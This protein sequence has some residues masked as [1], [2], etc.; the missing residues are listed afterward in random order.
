VKSFKGDNVNDFHVDKREPDPDRLVQAYFHSAATINY[1]RAMILGGVAD[2]HH[3][4]SWNLDF[5]QQQSTRKEYELIIE[6]ITDGLDF[7]QAIH[8]DKQLDALKSVDMYTSHEGLLLN[9]E[10]AL[11]KR[12][13]DQ[14][15]NL[16]AHFLWIGDRTRDINGAHIE[17]FRGIAN[18]IGVKVGPSMKPEELEELITILNPSKE[19]G[20]ISLITRYG[21]GNVEKMLPAHIRAVKKTGI[22]VLWVCDPCHGNTE[23]TPSG[24]KT[25]NV[26]KMMKELEASFE[27]HRKEGSHLGGVH[28]ELTG[29][30][31]TECVG[32][33]IELNEDSL[34]TAYETFCDPRLNYTQS[35]DAAFVVAAKLKADKSRSF[36]SSSN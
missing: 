35:L 26:E 32:G 20:K 11:T 17:Y 7:L 4:D 36:Q 28:L 33:S 31:V 5:I 29:D 14:Y 18:P 22:P 9:Y 23:V 10:E 15:Y 2:L 21:C 27:V 24:L 19:A 8:I 30:N 6:R 16:G 3:P 25:R 13:K 1:I 34:S 12:V